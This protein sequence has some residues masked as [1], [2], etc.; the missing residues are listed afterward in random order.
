M[1]KVKVKSIGAIFNDHP[2]GSTF[3]LTEQEAKHY[4]SLGYVELVAEE[5]KPKAKAESAPTDAAK[6]AEKPKPQRK[7]TKDK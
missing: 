7:T 5:S 2:I 3:E 1:A 4:A 6:S